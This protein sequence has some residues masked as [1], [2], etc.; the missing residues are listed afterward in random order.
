MTI[1]YK[2]SVFPIM[3]ILVAA[4]FAVTT[5]VFANLLA[6]DNQAA[7][8]IDIMVINMTQK[9]YAVHVDCEYALVGESGNIPRFAT[10]EF[11]VDGESSDSELIMP[12]AKTE[13]NNIY[14]IEHE[15]G[16]SVTGVDS[17]AERPVLIGSITRLKC[18]L[19]VIRN[20][21]FM[22]KIFCFSN[23]AG[24]GNLANSVAMPNNWNI[25]MAVY[26]NGYGQSEWSLL[27]DDNSAPWNYNGA[28]GLKYENSPIAYFPVV[29]VIYDNETAF[30][31]VINNFKTEYDPQRVGNM[32]YP[33]QVL[34]EIINKQDDWQNL[35]NGS[36][37]KA[38][39]KKLFFNKGETV[40]PETLFRGGGEAIVPPALFGGVGN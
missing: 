34:T 12:E 19:G 31:E 35:F 24:S 38:N 10:V 22:P 21:K 1:R 37:P 2:L 15:E 8:G 9:D 26:N 4:L 23:N 27:K 16:G 17:L 18:Q 32:F 25:G 7:Q 39:A 5:P 33:D 14:N 40:S 28:I 20:G 36:G 6:G 29:Y 3:V 11:E 13:S 30:D